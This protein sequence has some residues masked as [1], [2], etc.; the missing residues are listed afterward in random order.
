MPCTPNPLLAGKK[1]EDMVDRAE[2]L[3]AACLL[4]TKQGI[5]KCQ[6]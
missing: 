5:L 2:H 6:V 3:D 4:L 1:P